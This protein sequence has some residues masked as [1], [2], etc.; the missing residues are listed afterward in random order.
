MKTTVNL[1]DTT[2]NLILEN[3]DIFEKYKTSNKTFSIYFLRI[4]LKLKTP[5]CNYDI[6]FI[7]TV[8]ILFLTK[9]DLIKLEKNLNLR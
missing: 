6:F 5:N 1:I 3:E 8:Y 9:Q 4:D 2:L 7:S